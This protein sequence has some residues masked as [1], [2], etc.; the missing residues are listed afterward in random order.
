MRYEVTIQIERRRHLPRW[1]H[2]AFVILARR[3][4]GNV[5]G[6]RVSGWTAEG[7]EAMNTE[8]MTGGVVGPRPGGYTG[9]TGR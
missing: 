1:W 9:E 6:L 7:E 2:R 5:T 3:L 8:Y 4:P